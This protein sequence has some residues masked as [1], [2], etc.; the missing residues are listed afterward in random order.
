M[1]YFV[2][3]LSVLCHMTGSHRSNTGTVTGNNIRT[4]FSTVNKLLKPIETTT[5]FMSPLQ[6]QQ[7]LD[8]INHKVH[9]IHL[10]LT[11]S[12]SSQLDFPWPG[13]VYLLFNCPDSADIPADHIL[14]VNYMSSW[15]TSHHLG[16]GLPPCTLLSHYTNC[17]RLPVNWSCCLPAQNCLSLTHIKET[18]PWSKWF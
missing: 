8:F 15:Y 11:P 10:H 5:Q 12:L 1:I 7:F 4:L 3:T 16:Q 9:S 17:S 13:L 6:C 2:S 14:Q 18:W